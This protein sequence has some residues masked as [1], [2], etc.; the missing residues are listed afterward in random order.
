MSDAMNHSSRASVAATEELIFYAVKE[1]FIDDEPAS[2]E[3]LGTEPDVS[4]S[5]PG[6]WIGK[7]DLSAL[8]AL[9]CVM[10]LLLLYFTFFLFLL[11]RLFLLPFLVRLSFSSAS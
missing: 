11:L 10:R 1:L 7:A 3:K 2:E 8:P 5:M 9:A 6:R 4:A